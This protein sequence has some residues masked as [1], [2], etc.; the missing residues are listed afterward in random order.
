MNKVKKII[1]KLK[2]ASQK[3]GWSNRF[4]ESNEI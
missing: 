2:G 3:Y 1:D 4:R